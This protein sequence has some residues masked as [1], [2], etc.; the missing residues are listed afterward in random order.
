MSLES[1]K[2]LKIGQLVSKGEQIATLGEATVNGDYASHLHFQVI[3]DLEGKSGDYPGVCNEKNL[4]F[5]KQNCPDPNLL[6]KI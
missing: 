6:L 1:I 2:N 3:H 5:Y 4:S